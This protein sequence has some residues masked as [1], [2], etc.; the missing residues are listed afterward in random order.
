M[1]TVVVEKWVFNCDRVE[2]SE[3]YTGFLELFRDKTLIARVRSS[4][5]I[6]FAYN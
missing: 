1:I 5:I 2:P 3:S 6:L 4:E